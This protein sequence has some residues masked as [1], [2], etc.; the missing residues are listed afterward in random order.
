MSIAE[1]IQQVQSHILHACQIANRQPDEVTLVAVS[2]TKSS[3]EV[4]EAVNAG[5]RHFG[6][7]RVEEG[8]WKIP[9]VSAQT[10]HS[11]TWHM[12]GHLQSRKA[13]QVPSL[14]GV[15][16][17]VDSVKLAIKLAE[18]GNSDKKIMSVYLEINIS[19]EE[20]KEGLNAVG[21]RTN[22]NIRLELWKTMETLLKIEGLDIQGLMTMAP[23]YTEAEQPR[24]VFRELFELREALR[25]DFRIALPHLSMG[26]TNDYPIAIEEG[27]TV[28]RVGRAIF[29]E[30]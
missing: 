18:A 11:L 9:E 22:T 2:K 21:W 13:K 15:V 24:P 30:R 23:F 26:M 4:V 19:G 29:G 5:M 1:N 28:V 14:F 7:N 25:Q 20:S 17:S 3:A 6:E 10:A 16:H 27:A 12:I 8:T